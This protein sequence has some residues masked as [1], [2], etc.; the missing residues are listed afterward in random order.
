MGSQFRKSVMVGGIA[1]MLTALAACGPKSTPPPPPPPSPPPPVV[2]IPPRPMPPLGAAAGLFVPTMGPDG[3]RNTINAHISPAQTVW[4][5]RS[6]YNVAALNCLS[7]E[8]A[9]ILSGYKTFLKIQKKGLA[10][11][12]ATVDAEFKKKHGAGYIRPREAYMTQVYNF[13]AYPPTLQNFCDAALVVARESTT[14]KPA[15]LTAFSTRSLALLDSVFETFFRSYEQY[16]GDAA[17]WDAK[18]APKPASPQPQGALSAPA[19][20]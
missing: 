19:T 13:Y 18:Y 2:V 12:N 17:N 6:A 9:E 11:A 15:E 7:P 8:H 5:L 10:N 4:N 20:H 1:V 3:V 16:L 14:V